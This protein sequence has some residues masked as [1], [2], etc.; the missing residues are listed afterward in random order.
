MEGARPEHQAPTSAAPR[1][2][3]R[4]M[5]LARTGKSSCRHPAGIVDVVHA[6]AKVRDES[7]SRATRARLN[8]EP[9][10]RVQSGAAQG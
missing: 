7:T 6:P 5:T 4:L 9:E 2:P 1:S 3:R 8:L 10:I